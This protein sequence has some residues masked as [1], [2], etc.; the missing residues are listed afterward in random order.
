[1]AA[2]VGLLLS[3]TSALAVTIPFDDF[4]IHQL[5]VDKPYP[6]VT[7]TNSVPFN[8]GQ[9]TL[10]AKNVFG[11]GTAI[12]ATTMEVLDGELSFSNNQNATGTGT[13]SYSS[14]GDIAI[15]PNPFFFFDVGF[16]D[17]PANFIATAKDTFGN[18]GSYTEALVAGFDPYLYFSQFS[19]S[20]DFD[21]I[22]TLTFVI[23]T[24]GGTKGVDG[25]L[26]SISIGSIPLPAG[27][28]LLLSGIGLLAVARKKRSV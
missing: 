16:F 14:V 23:D 25:S 8:A 9:R 15:G 3:G 5:A 11:N 22:D 21:S 2:T 28:L 10:T 1:L 6:G 24:G 20:V 17:G 4:V 13:V 18:V 19:G 27:G 12:G 7:N 26:K